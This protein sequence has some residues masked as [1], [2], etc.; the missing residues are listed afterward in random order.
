[1]VYT[2]FEYYTLQDIQIDF[3]FFD[4]YV[5]ILHYN[6]IIIYNPF[7]ETVKTLKNIYIPPI[8]SCHYY[9]IIDKIQNK[10]LPIDRCPNVRGL[11]ESIYLWMCVCNIIK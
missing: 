8:C 3:T 10:L 2:I 6:Y 9:T 11:I 7:L 5:I 1:M 4:S